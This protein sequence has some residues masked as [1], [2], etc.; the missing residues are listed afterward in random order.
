MDTIVQYFASQGLDFWYIL[1]LCGALLVATMIFTLLARLVFGRHSL[2][3]SAISSCIGILFIYTLQIVFY[4]YPN[5]LA[6][7]IVPLPFTT[8]TDNSLHFFVFEGAHYTAVCSQLLSM[9]ILAFIMNIVD[10]WMPKNRN[11]ILWVVFR[12]LTLAIAI[13]IHNV[14]IQ[15]FNTLMPEGIVQ[16]A[17]VILLTILV[18]MLLTGALKLIVGALMAT[19]NP[20]IAALYT[21]FFASFVGK[22]VTR[23]VLTTAIMAG[24]VALFHTFGITAISIAPAALI[25]YIPFALVLVAMWYVVHSNQ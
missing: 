4:S 24:L 12:V 25:A 10:R 5:P 21:F 1:K 11:I 2:M 6:K 13:V 23:A 18:V 14:V 17:P 16:Y 7:Y 8:I 19:V 22:Q 9:I 15:I 3:N 20:L